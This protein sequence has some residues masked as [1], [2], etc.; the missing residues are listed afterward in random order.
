MEN[1]LNENS[2][3][4]Q[5]GRLT[6]FCML[7]EQPATHSLL[8]FKMDIPT[9]REDCN[10]Y[11][12]NEVAVTVQLVSPLG[13]TVTA[14]AF[15]HENYSFDDNHRIVSRV[16]LPS[17]R[18]RTALPDWGIW[19]LTATLTVDGEDVDFL[20][21]YV[22][23]HRREEPSR[24]LQVEPVRQ[25]TLA[26]NGKTVPLLGYNACEKV[27]HGSC[28]SRYLAKQITAL[29]ENGGNCLRVKPGEA[30]RNGKRGISQKASAMWDRLFELAAAHNLYFIVALLN[31]ADLNGWLGDPAA[32][33]YY[34]LYLRY[35]VSRWGYSEQVA[36]WELCHEADLATSV[37]QGDAASMQA[38]L[39]E[40]AALVRSTDTQPHML[41]ASVLFPSA[42]PLVQNGL[43]VTTYLQLNYY[44]VTMLTDM[45]KSAARAYHRPSFIGETGLWGAGANLCGGTFP[46]DLTVMHQGNWAGLMGGGIGTAFQQDGAGVLARNAVHTFRGISKMATSIPWEDPTLRDATVYNTTVSHHQ[47]GL[48]GYRG[49]RG[50]YLWL[51]DAAYMPIYRTETVFQETT[52]TLPLA[53]GTY[54]VCCFNTHTGD[55]LTET[56]GTVTA[57]SLTVTL[58]AWSQDIAVIVTAEKGGSL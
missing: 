32:A 20:T 33:D 24:L 50:A 49:E 35:A 6:G 58:P 27:P 4:G 21:G 52:V 44:S 2:I 46:A 29:S 51:Y 22:I 53:A 8:E 40:V 41:T 16:G 34:R 57:G 47:I 7:T 11:D 19:S 10:L 54:R 31:Y 37:S 12:P 5:N 14:Q 13:R 18:V 55:L 3:N 48:L 30:L 36:L 42:M 25:R 17:F 15:F 28:L 45:Q 56:V 23:V 43:D 26:A 39:Q 9:L 38:C 1:I